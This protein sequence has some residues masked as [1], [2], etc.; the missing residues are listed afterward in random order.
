[1]AD[2][3]LDALGP[4]L[5][6]WTMGG[7]AV[8]HAPPVWR[9]ALE[10][11]PKE[12]ELRLLALSGQYLGTLTVSPPAG[13]LQPRGDIPVLACPPL[14]EIFRPGARR[15]L[16]ALREPGARRDLL[17]FLDRRGWTLHPG[18]WMPR[19]GDDVPPVYAPWQDWAATA[20]SAGAE[21][22]TADTWGEF[23]PA[24]RL[25]ALMDLRGHDAA[26][27]TALLLL[28]IAGEPA[29]HR[30]RLL[31]TLV[32]G[33]SENDRPLLELLA[34]G[35]RAPRVRALATAF[36]EGLNGRTSHQDEEDAAKL[37]AFF[38]VQTRGL[39]R[40]TRVIE[41]LP[42]KNIVYRNRRTD[43]FDTVSFD[44]FARTLGL[45]GTELVA[46][47]PWGGDALLDQGFAQMV[48]RSAADPV[49][50]ATADALTLAK[51][52]D[53]DALEMLLPRLTAG[54]RHV[55]AERL[56]RANGATFDMVRAIAGGDGC[57]DDAI[58][59]PAGMALLGALEAGGDQA[60]ELLALGLIASRKA[61]GQA[62]DQLVVVGLIA[63][64]PRLDMLRLNAA[65]ENRR[66]TE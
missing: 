49:V 57:I 36:I 44:G 24:A 37:A 1:M 58:H 11:D 47:W 14:P 28:K 13:D 33:L 29:D 17:N 59:M 19:P 66:P 3:I 2:A 23:G 52:I 51:T 56:V 65:L 62:L 22:L 41:P 18:D 38:A 30:V 26:A 64:D 53:S 15:L 60:D 34:S 5:T 16:H 8:R 50:A 6:R 43:L 12:A 54:Q 55:A 61:A 63:S 48:A 21:E 20:A 31:Q 9:E 46:I 42:P 35:D 40:R 25:A 32:L 27:A 10:S 7:S 45:E 39:L 4:V